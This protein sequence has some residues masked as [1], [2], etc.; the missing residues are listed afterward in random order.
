MKFATVLFLGLVSAV[1]IDSTI[2]AELEE[3]KHKKGDM[4]VSRK[5]ADEIFKHIDTNHDGQV[6]EEELKSALEAEVK[7]HG[8]HPTKEQIDWVGKTAAD[9]AARHGKGKNKDT[10]NK[11]EFRGFINT[12][13][14]HFDMCH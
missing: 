2:E 10:M 6:D 12:F 9:F 5:E 11:R 3:H 14:K 8:I 1:K 13:A 4:C 7:K